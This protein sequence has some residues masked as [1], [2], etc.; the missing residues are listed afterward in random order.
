[1]S[2]VSRETSAGAPPEPISARGV[3]SVDRMPFARDYAELLAGPGTERGLIG[4]RE[5]SRL[6]DRHILNSAV[7]G[8]RVPD[9]ST[10]CDIGSGAGLPGI[11]LAIARPDLDVTLVEPLLRRATF[12]S[13]VVDELGLTNVVVL[14]ARAEELH[15]SASLSPG[16]DVVTS[17]AVAPLGRLLAWSMP[18]VSPTGRLLALKG[19]SIGEEVTAAAPTLSSMRLS[20]PTVH[21]VGEGRVDEPTSVLE[22]AWR[23]P[24]SVVWGAAPRAS[25]S[26]P[27]QRKRRR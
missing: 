21:V 4:P 23:D 17:R 15:G 19:S 27:R 3:F 11:P 1:M 18:L 20:P 26:K 14:R 8:E 25:S 12:L 24:V 2:D 6:W 9:G 13:E 16:F 10:V 22:V 7:L 5:R